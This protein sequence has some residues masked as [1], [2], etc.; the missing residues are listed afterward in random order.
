MNRSHVLWNGCK[1]AAL[2]T[3][4]ALP[5]LRIRAAELSSPPVFSASGRLTAGIVYR[6]EAPDSRL[7]FAL[8][9]A[10]AGV[11]ALNGTG[12]NAD[13]A[14]LNFRRHDAVSRAISGTLDLQAHYQST[15]AL[16]RIRGW[17][18]GALRDDGRSWGSTAN[19]YTPGAPLSDAGA[20]PL[21]RF[22]GGVRT[23]PRKIV[24]AGRFCTVCCASIQ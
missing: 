1:L 5:G 13:D 10:A 18:D 6:L 11:P 22:S 21:S 2:A 3:V 7:P 19:N 9:G 20:P 12:A 14:N 16:L 24:L 17:R 15:R 23:S 8:N 4:L